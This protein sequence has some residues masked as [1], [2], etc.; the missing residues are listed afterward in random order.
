[1]MP[2]LLLVTSCR[3]VTYDWLIFCALLAIFSL[4]VPDACL[5]VSVVS[6]DCIK[7]GLVNAGYSESLRYNKR[8]KVMSS[9]IPG[10]N[11]EK[12]PLTC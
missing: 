3:P 11:L 1:M 5:G 6:V 9:C 7:A 4:G 10:H 12:T 8:G 2:P